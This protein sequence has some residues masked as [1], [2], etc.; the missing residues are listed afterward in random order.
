MMDPF[1]A[2]VLCAGLGVSIYLADRWIKALMAIAAAAGV[3]LILAHDWRDPA[4]VFLQR[5]LLGRQVFAEAELVTA[6]SERP[7]NVKLFLRIRRMEGA[8]V[9]ALVMANVDYSHPLAHA[10]PGDVFWIQGATLL[11]IH[12]FHNIGDWDYE[13]YMADQ[14]LGA[15]LL[16]RKKTKVY[17]IGGTWSVAR[18]MEGARRESSLKLASIIRDP[19]ALAVTRAILTG[20]QGLVNPELRDIFSRAG[21]AHIL[22]VSGLHV[23]FIAAVVYFVFR[24]ALFFLIYPM[25]RRWAAAGVPMR[26][27]AAM[28]I[29]VVWLFLLFTGPPIPALRSGIMIGVYLM[30]VALGRPREFYSSFTAAM[31]II[32]VWSPWSLF[33]V[34]FQLSFAAIYFITIFLE[35]YLNP[36]AGRDAQTQLSRLAPGWWRVA[37]ERFPIITGALASSVY[38]TVGSGPLVAHHFHTISILG[39]LINIPVIILGSVAT[40]LGIAGLLADSGIMIRWTAWLCH[41]IV[42]MSWGGSALPLAYA[43]ITIFPEAACAALYVAMVLFIIIRPG[44]KRR[45]AAGMAALAAMAI[46]AGGHI[47]AHMETGMT[48]RFLDVGQGDCTMITW[49]GGAAVVDTGMSNPVFDAGRMVAAPALWRR[50]RGR[51]DALFI[52]HGDNDH[53]GGAMGLMDRA[54]SARVYGPGMVEVQP[55]LASLRGWAM[56]EGKYHP[57]NAGQTLD[58]PGGPRIIVLNPPAGKAPFNPTTNNTALVL[59]VV[60]G[61]VSAIL[62]SDVGAAA[63]RWLAMEGES[64]RSRVLKIAHHGSHTSS[65]EEFLDAVRP[66]YAVIS[67]GRDNRHGHPAVQ[68]LER[69]KRRGI[70]VLRTDMD[71]EVVLRTDGV[72]LEISTFASLWPGN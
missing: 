15:R 13:R 16:I 31:A 18:M 33:T 11:P 47:R 24:T 68:T 38:A 6:D 10:L 72:N 59:K 32:L 5:G 50:G 29:P 2:A 60:Y 30:A 14:G 57:L 34:S 53:I 36:P 40:P 37:M 61:G 46:V 23:G 70:K 43:Y 41:L 9:S 4:D 21:T 7:R 19:D 1:T 39:P 52:T 44:R 55:A 65:S 27:A 69:L 49:P 17:R 48:I 66:E 51:L 42:A 71:G 45:Q 58:F 3:A 64:I 25:R 62:P 8:R 54:P 35:M 12:G 28:A 26:L 22:S 67:A 56:A 63:E 20:D